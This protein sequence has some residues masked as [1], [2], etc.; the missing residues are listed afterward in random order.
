[1]G[2]KLGISAVVVSLLALTFSMISP[3]FSEDTYDARTIRLVDKTAD[4]DIKLVDVGK[5]GLSVGDYAIF[6]GDPL[7]TP[8]LRHR[9]G[10]LRGSSFAIELGEGSELS[11]AED[12]F[13]FSLRDGDITTE[14]TNDF[15]KDVVTFAVTGGTGA[16]KSAHGEL[17]VDYSDPDIS[18]YTFKL[19][20]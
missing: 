17:H 10:R 12:D 9:V 20:L 7:F 6:G 1:M 2:R 16:Y 18:R 11:L 19:L 5:K 14:G 8:S 15:S 3:A 13:T 4:D